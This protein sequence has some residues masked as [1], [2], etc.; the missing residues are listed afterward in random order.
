MTKKTTDK[1][2]FGEL[3]KVP[4]RDVWSKEATEFTPWLASN[5]ENLGKAL[6]MELE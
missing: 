1:T 4:L 2:R 5:I 6:G 3:K